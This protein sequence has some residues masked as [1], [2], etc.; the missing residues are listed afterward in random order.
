MVESPETNQERKRVRV[1]Q[2][3]VKQKKVKQKRVN[4]R[5][6]LLL[7]PFFFF[8]FQTTFLSDMGIS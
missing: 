5:D 4:M 6:D 8:R 7:R 3:K 1:K 2:K